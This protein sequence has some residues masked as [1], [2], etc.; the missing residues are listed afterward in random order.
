M[1]QTFH[2]W[3]IGGRAGLPPPGLQLCPA[4]DGT[5][6]EAI[7]CSSLLLSQENLPLGT[8]F[9]PESW[10]RR[11]NSYGPPPGKGG[12]APLIPLSNDNLTLVMYQE[13]LRPQLHA[14]LQSLHPMLQPLLV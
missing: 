14:T 6:N 11:P 7:G 4:C 5:Q 2:T 12:R 10:G 9:I 13:I 3:D 8:G 1:Q